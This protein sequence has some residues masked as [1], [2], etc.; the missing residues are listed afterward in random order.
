MPFVSAVGVADGH[1]HDNDGRA[2]GHRW[3]DT[4]NTSAR[5]NDDG[6]TNALTEDP[7]GRSD[8]ADFR[9]RDGRRLEA[10]AGFQHGRGGVVHD[11]ILCCPA[12]L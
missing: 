2:R 7:V 9:R 3:G 5:A 4:G 11:L 1:A 8:A 6:S 12:T 10:E